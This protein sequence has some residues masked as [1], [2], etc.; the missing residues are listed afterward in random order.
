MNVSFSPNNGLVNSVPD[1]TLC[2]KLSIL[3]QVTVVPVDIV[4]DS[5]GAYSSET[6]LTPG[7]G[8]GVVLGAG[9]GVGVAAGT[10]I[11][12]GEGAGVGVTDGVTFV[13]DPCSVRLSIAKNSLLVSLSKARFLET[14]RIL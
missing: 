8:V 14:Q 2:S 9:T 12:V 10:G 4:N 7:V 3:V 11:S 6:F 1:V 5:S 13:V